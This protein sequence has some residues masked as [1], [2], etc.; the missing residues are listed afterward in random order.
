MKKSDPYY[1]GNDPRYSDIAEED[2]PLTE[3]LLDC[4]ERARPLWEYKIRKDI[5]KGNNVLVIA[6]TNTLRGLIKQID[7]ERFVHFE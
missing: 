6:H 4:Q 3:S 2:I 1:P 5:E 7:C